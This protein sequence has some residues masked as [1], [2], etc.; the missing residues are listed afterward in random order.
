MNGQGEM[1][2]EDGRFYKGEFQNDKKHGKGILF[3]PNGRKIEGTWILG[4]QEGQ[5]K[6]INKNG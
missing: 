1:L 5:G 2:Y 4:K 3:L 6:Y